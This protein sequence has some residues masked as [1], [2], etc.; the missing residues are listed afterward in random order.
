MRPIRRQRGFSLVEIM[1]ALTLSLIL[2]GGVL[3]VMYSSKVTYMENER[4]GRLQ[5]NGRAA[6]RDDPS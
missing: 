6:T 5:E 3:A 1:V 4:V 2:L